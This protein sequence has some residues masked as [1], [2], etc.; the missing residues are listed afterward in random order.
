M[1][2]SGFPFERRWNQK[3]CCLLCGV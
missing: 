2:L 1:R 3:K